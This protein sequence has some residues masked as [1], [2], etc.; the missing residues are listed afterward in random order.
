[1]PTPPRS[2]HPAGDRDRRG[3]T[4]VTR[5]DE[6][7]VADGW[8]GTDGSWHATDPATRRALQLAQGADEH[9]DGPPGAPVWV[10]RR[11]DDDP[12]WS[13]ATLV[14]E[15]GSELR[16]ADRLP[17]DLPTGAH[18]LHPDDGGPTTE[19]FVTPRRSPRP[20]WGWG[21][22]AQLY[23]TRSARSWGHGNLGDLAALAR[24]AADSG[25]A[26]IAHNPLGAPLPTASQQPSPYYASTRRFWSPLYLDVAAVDGAELVG[27]ELGPLE[28]RARALSTAS[29]IDRDELWRTM[30]RALEL[31]WARVRTTDSGRRRLRDAGTDRTLTRYATFCAIA[32][33]ADA[34]WDRWPAALRHPDSP[35]VA[36]F[37]AEHADEVDFHRWVQL[38]L[39]RQLARAA[40][41]GAGLLA[42]LPV[43]FDPA[44][45]D[46]WCDQDLLARDC[47]VGAPPD[48]LGPLGQDWGL[49]PYV[50]WKLR[51]AAY[52]PWLDTLRR[53]L[54]HATALRIDH[55]MGL[56][57]LFWIPRGADPRSGGYVLQHGTDLLDLA[58][59]E[60]GRAG[61]S[62]VGEDLGTVEPHVRDALRDRDV[63]GYRV[64]WFDDDPASWP[65]STLASVTTHDLPTV[66]GLWTG[67]D[68]QDRERAGLPA[69]PEADRE[70]RDRLRRL[71]GAG[72]DAPVR[73]VVL[74]AHRGIARSGS[75]LAIAT[76]EDAVGVEHRPNVPGTV[77]EH[78]NWRI[79]LP[80][81][82]EELDDAGASEVAQVMRDGRR[83]V[84]P[85]NDA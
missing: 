24:W 42:D 85:P 16:T 69:D 14:L 23:A 58:V 64:G 55:V 12:L 13:P 6:W 73:D 39:D 36:R 72:D 61:A 84:R 56:F 57:R 45:F 43:G 70:L 82:V 54:R 35:A 10:V 34:G 50:P 74:G 1:M 37:A 63:F 2:G 62:I 80:A 65:P 76:L 75:D 18:R 51:A 19:L 60:A 3:R 28:R 33:D 41:A 53:V 38:E 15:D 59:M 26:V 5:P 67:V 79:P 77:D 25:A 46:A 21:W 27:E 20:P 32:R 40:S 30:V 8:W 66:A 71:A 52:E 47:R 49:P 68:A 44:G 7:A 29:L 31:V 22:S 81:L 17:T 11:G 48:D 9:P 83:D 4:V 78:P